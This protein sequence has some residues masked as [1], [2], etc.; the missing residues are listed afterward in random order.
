[1]TYTFL[2][3]FQVDPQENE[4]LPQQ[5][6]TEFD[7]EGVTLTTDVDN[8]LNACVLELVEDKLRVKLVCLLL[9]VGLQTSDKMGTR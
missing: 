9:L 6:V 5:K 3:E 7:A 8:L 2:P 4:D 1:M